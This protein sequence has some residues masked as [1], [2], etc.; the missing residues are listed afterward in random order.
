M[1]PERRPRVW[2]DARLCKGTEGCG[3]CVDRCKAEVL[4]PAAELSPRGVHV[5]AVLHPDQCTGCGLCMLFCPDLAAVVEWEERSEDD[6][7]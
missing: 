6:G 4:G 3:I 2:I 1:P 7:R 5:A